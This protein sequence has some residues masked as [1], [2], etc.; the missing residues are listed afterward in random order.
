[1]IFFFNKEILEKSNEKNITI[2]LLNGKILF[3][4]IFKKS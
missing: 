2:I 1:M 3:K 4:K